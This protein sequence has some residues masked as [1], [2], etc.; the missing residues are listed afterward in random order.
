MK[1]C[2]PIE[3]LIYKHPFK[4]ERESVEVERNTFR[5]IY[6]ELDLEWD[7][8]DYI[9]LD[10]DEIV[11]DYSAVPKSE[12]ISIKCVPKGGMSNQAAATAEK[13]VGAMVVIAAVAIAISPIG[14]TAGVLA[15]G[16]S[17]LMAIGGGVILY[18]TKY[19]YG[20]TSSGAP[21]N[22]PSISGSKNSVNPG[23]RIPVLLGRHL[24]FPFVASNFYTTT[25]GGRLTPPTTLSE[26]SV[27]QYLHLLLCSGYANMEIHENTLQF[28]DIPISS[29][30]DVWEDVNGAYT[31]SRH[32]NIH[33]PVRVVQDNVGSELKRLDIPQV[34]I[35]GSEPPT[36][37]EYEYIVRTTPKNTQAIDITLLFPSGL[38]YVDKD[39]DKESTYSRLALEWKSASAP[40]SAYQ[41]FGSNFYGEYL[42]PH[43]IVHIETNIETTA[44]SVIYFNF[45][46]TNPDK[47]YTI[48]VS[49]VSTDCFWGEARTKNKLVD[50]VYWED[51]KSYTVDDSGNTYPINPDIK[52]NLNVTSWK[53][54]ATDQ[55]S[56]V[57]DDIN[58]EATAY[59]RQYLGSGSG[60][61]RWVNALTSNP[62]SAFV[63]VLT[64]SRINQKPILPSEEATKID[65]ESLETWWTFCNDKGL[66]C[67]AY[68]VG[69]VT[70]NT[71]LNNICSTAMASWA[72]VDNKYTIIIDTYNYDIIQYF[73]PRNS[74]NF[75]GSKMFNDIPTCLKMQFVDKDNGY[76]EGERYVYYDSYNGDP[77]ANDLVEEVALY[78]AMGADQAWRLGRYTHASVRLRPEIF[79]FTT[80]IEYIMCTRGDRIRLNHDVPLFGLSNGRIVNPIQ[81]S[82][83]TMGIVLDELMQFEEGKEYGVTIR[84]QD[85]TSIEKNVV[86]PAIDTTTVLFETPITGEDILFEDDL[87]LFG[88]RGSKDVD[89][90]VQKI[91][92]NDDLGA[93]ITCVEY[94]EAI[95]TADTSIPIPP[96]D[97]KIS[98]GGSSTI[99]VGSLPESQEDKVAQTQQVTVLTDQ[100]TYSMNAK[101]PDSFQ[102][103]SVQGWYPSTFDE[104]NYI[105][106]NYDD[107]NT[108]Y[109]KTLMGDENGVKINNVS[110]RYPQV[111]GMMA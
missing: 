3:V 110:S 111:M 108:I 37:T 20:N 96:Y 31:E 64:D 61:S 107:G 103:T 29:Y 82:G 98:K 73:T 99:N 102:S 67:N 5:K 55:L 104:F 18:N 51:M 62:A 70:V 92:P 44:R 34:N 74:S 14:L 68:E 25:Q 35:M 88:E 72:I 12:Y 11:K 8:D 106:V 36:P 4:S 26:S 97:P 46:N 23:G 65:W 17:G 87:V 39:G 6:Q 79:S 41:T 75:S 30:E 54:R 48:R 1:S 42:T 71:M 38:Y 56:Q 47:Q 21:L 89:L 43:N 53:I 52:E 33:Y 15:L 45:P 109:K 10:G 85:G 91:E 105:Y 50:T 28:G 84:L 19:D 66:E 49:N 58:Y 93:T 32:Q 95:Y 27:N 94:N 57:V 80:D 76:I 60:P 100:I 22:S 86:N 59:S 24:T 101:F 2:K 40:D 13:A 69:D 7:I 81:D 83:L 16:V 77:R 78:G 9:I 63:K 90:I